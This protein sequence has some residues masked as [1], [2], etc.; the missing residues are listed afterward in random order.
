MRTLLLLLIVCA[1]CSPQ[2]AVELIEGETPWETHADKC[3][4]CGRFYHMERTVEESL[5]G[6]PI[7]CDEGPKLYSY[8]D[9]KRNATR[10][11]QRHP[12]PISPELL[13]K[14]RPTPTDLK[15][16]ELEKRIGELESKNE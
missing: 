2:K 8:T 15:I 7:M 1:G 4:I 14:Y 3:S 13:A 10:Q 12:R 16:Q 9:A 5:R 11:M 6:D